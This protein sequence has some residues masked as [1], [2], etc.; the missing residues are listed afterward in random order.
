MRDNIGMGRFWRW[1]RQAW[2]AF[3]HLRAFRDLLGALT[4]WHYVLLGCALVGG[5]AL[6]V[7]SWVTHLPGPVAVLVGII[8]VLV[9]MGLL[10]LTIRTWRQL[11]QRNAANEQFADGT[12]QEISRPPAWVL[13]TIAIVLILAGIGWLFN[14][15]PSP[16][17]ASPSTEHQSGSQPQAKTQQPPTAAQETPKPARQKK[18]IKPLTGDAGR[19]D[20]ALP[21]PNTAQ[22]ATTGPVTVQSGGAASFGQQGGI[23]AGQIFIGPPPG[24]LLINGVPGNMPVSVITAF[25]SAARIDA[26]KKMANAVYVVI[27][28]SEV[29]AY[30]K[31]TTRIG[32]A[33][34]ILSSNPSFIVFDDTRGAYVLKEPGP[35][36]R[37]TGIYWLSAS[38]RPGLVCYFNQESKD[39]AE[40]IQKLLEPLGVKTSM[41]WQIRNDE[42][43]PQQMDRYKF[44][45]A[46]G[47][48]I[49][50]SL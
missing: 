16:T 28:L 42:N 1:V 23:T 2:D 21:T 11:H 12:T 37:T 26:T 49:E 32:E 31:L 44:W 41:Y 45:V 18:T 4:V 22:G 36:L 24:Q 30:N 13:T 25:V 29:S 10:S 15:K 35:D 40:T 19:Q 8:A 3:R 43:D 17:D 6:A 50:I 38:P 47:I 7:W 46:S 34:T 20:A 48:D 33:R 9:I 27:H 5:L 39:A 14:R